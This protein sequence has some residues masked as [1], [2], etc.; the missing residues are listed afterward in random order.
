MN[1]FT[2]KKPVP[3][4][5]DYENFRY[6]K[7]IEVKINLPISKIV[8]TALIS[9]VIGLTFPR[10]LLSSGDRSTPSDITQPRD[11]KGLVSLQRQ[12][13]D[14]SR[15][16]KGILPLLQ[17]ARVEGTPSEDSSTLEL[18]KE[19]GSKRVVTIATPKANLRASP[20]NSSKVVSTFEKGT[21]LLVTN[22]NGEWLQV[23]L[24]SGLTAW[25][26]AD[27]TTNEGG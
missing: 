26:R 3:W 21:Q 14:I 18:Q 11:E 13:D 10:Y 2:S 15:V 12:I 9:F 27:L 4:H 22:Q 20:S 6:E 25:I 23:T 5:S 17:G 19:D 1:P 7:S 8:A 16:L 24:P